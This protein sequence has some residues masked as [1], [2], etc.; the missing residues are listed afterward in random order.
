MA[1]R[2]T[3]DKPFSEAMLFC[4]TDAYASLGLSELISYGDYLDHFDISEY[5]IESEWVRSVSVRNGN[6]KCSSQ[7]AT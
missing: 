7:L 3:A 4:C 6:T 5:N 2:Q 1:W